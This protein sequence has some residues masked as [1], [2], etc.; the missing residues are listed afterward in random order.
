MNQLK[1]SGIA[2]VL[3]TMV[4]FNR[5]TPIITTN[6]TLKMAVLSMQSPSPN[7]PSL[8]YRATEALKA[9]I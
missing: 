1:G 9:T 7:L 4:Q 5:A 3:K 2:Q 8:M 6:V